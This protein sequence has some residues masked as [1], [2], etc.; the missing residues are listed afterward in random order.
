MSESTPMNG[1]R[2][3][4]L[5]SVRG[6]PASSPRRT[7][8]KQRLL[9]PHLGQRCTRLSYAEYQK[10]YHRTCW[11]FSAMRT[12]SKQSTFPELI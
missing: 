10:S 1:A 7:E 2:G 6:L 11:P 9:L 5:P 8:G 12:G 4:N 3:M